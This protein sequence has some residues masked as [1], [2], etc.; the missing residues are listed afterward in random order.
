MIKLY[1]YYPSGNSYKIE[2][3]LTHLGLPYQFIDMDVMA[4]ATRTP[5]FLRINPNGRVPVVEIAPGRH[6]SESNAILFYFGERSEF[7]PTDRWER[8]LV[9]QWMNF[10]QYHLEP[11]VGTARLHLQILRKK[12]EQCPLDLAGRQ[13]EAKR[14]IGLIDQHLAER[15]FMVGNRFS[16]AD[17]CLYAYVHVAPEGHID[18]APF[19]HVRDWLARI[20]GLPGHIPMTRPDLKH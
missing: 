2:L 14:A 15:T 19:T 20:A 16:L 17:I 6:L 5:Q 10:E 12:P 13:N 3:A 11:H 9:L 7:M 4:G 1:G 18:L 8:G